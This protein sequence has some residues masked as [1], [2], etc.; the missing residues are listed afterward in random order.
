MTF[1]RMDYVVPLALHSMTKGRLTVELTRRRESKLPS[2]HQVSCE[3]RSRRSRPTIWAAVC[4]ELLVAFPHS[5]SVLR[6]LDHDFTKG[7]VWILFPCLRRAV[8]NARFQ[9]VSSS[10]IRCRT[11][12]GNGLI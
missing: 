1:R 9:F 10:V 12:V 8:V 6:F 3:P 2:P 7:R 5:F 4:K 11:L